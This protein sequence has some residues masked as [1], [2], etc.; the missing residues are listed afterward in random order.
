[1][2]ENYRNAHILIE[3]TSLLLNSNRW[4]RYR[5]E[6]LL[7]LLYQEFGL[8]LRER[9]KYKWFFG[10]ILYL[11]PWYS[12]PSQ[13]SHPWKLPDFTLFKSWKSSFWSSFKEV[14]AASSSVIKKKY[15]WRLTPNINRGNQLIA[16]ISRF[17][18]NEARGSESNLKFHKELNF[19]IKLARNQVFFSDGHRKFSCMVDVSK[20]PW[21]NR[22]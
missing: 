22:K 4:M 17:Q 10:W 12:T 1:M 8:R 11:F 21:L 6:K 19:F 16:N 13:S 3:I 14:F 7:K 20:R 18:E 2:I 9:K 5:G 15:K